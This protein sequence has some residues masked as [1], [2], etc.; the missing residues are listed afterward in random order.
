MSSIINRLKYR[1]TFSCEIIRILEYIMICASSVNTKRT[2]LQ[3]GR[4]RSVLPC[5]LV[6]S[7]YRCQYWDKHYHQERRYCLCPDTK[8]LQGTI[9]KLNSAVYHKKVG[10]SLRVVLSKNLNILTCKIR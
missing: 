3:L 8:S 10:I 2:Y 4:I 5:R 9:E 6:E 7:V 1:Q